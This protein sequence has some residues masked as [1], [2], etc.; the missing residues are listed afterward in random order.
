MA[1]K[2]EDT[3]F[4][5]RW[6]RRKRLSALGEEPVAAE[7]EVSAI[8][9]KEDAAAD[10]ELARE[11]EENRKAAEAVDIDSLTYED[12]FQVFLKQGV[13][14]ALRKQALR[15]LWRSNPV[16][17]NLDGLNDYDEDF[18]DPSDNVYAS[19]WKV[20]RGFLSEAEQKAQQEEG[21]ISAAYETDDE[22]EDE[23][24]PDDDGKPSEADPS[25]IDVPAEVAGP[26]ANPEDASEPEQA[27]TAEPPSRVSI[28]RRLEG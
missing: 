3:G 13:P 28:R 12:D 11:L 5:S 21:R 26:V 22:V 1:E 25:I 4:L 17:A 15:K 8:A 23:A 27:A 14:D 18:A 20:G 7:R 24:V 9:G 10:E 19:I 16:L 2:D 6:S